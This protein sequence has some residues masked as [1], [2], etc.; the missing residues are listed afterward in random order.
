[1]RRRVKCRLFKSTVGLLFRKKERYL[2]TGELVDESGE[3]QQ[4]CHLYVEEEG[5]K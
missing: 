2:L 1:M 3:G 5:R 4:V